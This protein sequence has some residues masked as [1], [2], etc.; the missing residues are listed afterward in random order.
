MSGMSCG[1]CVRHVTDEVRKVGGVDSVAVDL[2]ASTVTVSGTG[3][4]VDLVRSAI[5]EAGYEPAAAVAV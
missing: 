3:V 5:I 2:V 4:D 1:S